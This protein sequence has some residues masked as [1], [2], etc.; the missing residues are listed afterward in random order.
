MAETVIVARLLEYLDPWEMFGRVDPA[1]PEEPRY[2]TLEMRE[3]LEAA[4]RLRTEYDAP[5]VRYFAGCVRRGRAARARGR[6]LPLRPGDG[7]PG[8]NHHRRLAPLRRIGD[9]GRRA[10]EDQL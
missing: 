6:G 2:L 4:G 9:V 7:L 5:R 3:E 8:A 10:H 1:G